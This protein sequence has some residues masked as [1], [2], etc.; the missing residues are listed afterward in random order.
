MYIFLSDFQ[1]SLDVLIRSNMTIHL[2]NRK[3]LIDILLSKEESKH[4]YLNF[5]KNC[6]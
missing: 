1:A 3:V 6:Q 5:T 4:K 2:L